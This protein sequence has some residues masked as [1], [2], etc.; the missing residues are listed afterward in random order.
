MR[1]RPDNKF[2]RPQGLAGVFC[3]LL[4]A[5]LE[6]ADAMPKMPGFVAKIYS[7]VTKDYKPLNTQP[8][9]AFDNETKKYA[10]Y[11]DFLKDDGPRI[12]IPRVQLDARL[13]RSRA[14]TAA[15][16]SPRCTP[17]SRRSAARG[18]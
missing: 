14:L 7:E 3:S 5:L 1:F 4:R 17:T 18:W 15:S 6:P 11:P 9:K 16:G 8:H 13:A 2:F 12:E 10:H